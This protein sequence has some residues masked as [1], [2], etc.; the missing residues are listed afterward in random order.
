MLSKGRA[1]V[2]AGQLHDLQVPAVFGHFRDDHEHGEV[3]HQIGQGIVDGG[4]VARLLQG[5]DADEKVTGVGDG[6]VGQHALEVFLDDGHQV[7]QGHGGD[8]KNHQGLGEAVTVADAQG[9]K[10]Q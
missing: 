10:A 1:A 4:D 8:G 9:G 2:E 7:A 5:Q 6:G 3:H